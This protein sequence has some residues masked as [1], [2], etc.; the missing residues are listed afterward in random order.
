MNMLQLALRLSLCVLL[1]AFAAFFLPIAWLLLKASIEASSYPFSCYDFPV[2]YAVALGVPCAVFIT[3]IHALCLVMALGFAAII[4]GLILMVLRCMARAI[5]A[6]K[7]ERKKEENEEPGVIITNT[8]PILFHPQTDISGSAPRTLTAV[9]DPSGGSYRWIILHGSEKI[10]TPPSLETSDLFLDPK[11]PSSTHGD[12]SIKVEYTSPKGNTATA[13]ASLTIYEP[14]SAKVI[15]KTFTPHNG[16]TVYGWL[17]VHRYRILDQFGDRFPPSNL[18]LSEQL[19][20]IENPFNT[21]F[22]PK[23]WFS[24]ENAEYDD[25]YEL[26]MSTPVPSNYRARVRQVVSAQGSV[27]LDHVLLWEPNGVT[28]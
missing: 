17:H 22:V 23:E 4:L 8:G 20:P 25:G 15:S 18:H 1:A 13:E 6:E 7:D 10:K 2:A 9:G 16:P 12:L 3:V 27:I 19:T 5:K 26:R 21:T 24:D 14:S 11:A 28:I